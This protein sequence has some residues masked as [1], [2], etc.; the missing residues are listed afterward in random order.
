MKQPFWII[1]EL[2]DQPKQA[3]LRNADKYLRG[4]WIAFDCNAFGVLGL[5][6]YSAVRYFKV[7]DY[8]HDQLLS[9]IYYEK[10]KYKKGIWYGDRLWR[11]P[12]MSIE[13]AKQRS[14]AEIGKPYFSQ[15]S[16][17]SVTGPV[18]MLI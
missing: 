14:I 1:G 3:F 10:R 16:N 7:C 11:E 8:S 9:S 5:P 4:L 12:C 18:Y 6:A 15:S 2:I 13:G 17:A